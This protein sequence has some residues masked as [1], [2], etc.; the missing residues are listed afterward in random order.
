M[1]GEIMKL[2][3]ALVSGVAALGFSTG[4]AFAGGE[5]MSHGAMSQDLMSQGSFQSYEQGGPD[6]LSDAQPV[7]S[8]ERDYTAMPHEYEVYDVYIVPAEEIVLIPFEPSE[9]PI[10]GNE[11]G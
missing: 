10:A 1:K 3:K 8:Q 6:L 11:L 2:I 7:D 4:A 5:L 9:P